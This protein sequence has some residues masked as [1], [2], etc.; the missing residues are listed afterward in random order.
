MAGP[1][2]DER[3]RRRNRIGPL[4]PGP[5]S[6]VTVR[7]LV[8]PSDVPLATDALAKAG[9]WVWVGARADQLRPDEDALLSAERRL[10]WRTPSATTVR[11]QAER[12]AEALTAGSVSYDLV[13]IAVERIRRPSWRYVRGGYGAEIDEHILAG[14]PEQE[15]RDLERVAR[16]HG[17]PVES[18]S[19]AVVPD[20]NLTATRDLLRYRPAAMGLAVIVALCLAAIAWR[21][22]R[23]GPGELVVLAL[24]LGSGLGVYA[25]RRQHGTG[26]LRPLVGQLVAIV[27]LFTAFLVGVIYLSYAYFYAPFGVTPTEVGLTTQSMLARQ[28]FFIALW[29]AVIVAL[30]LMVYGALWSVPQLQSVERRVDVLQAAM[31]PLIV[32]VAV[33]TVLSLT[34]ENGEELGGAARAG[35]PYD[36]FSGGFSWPL[37]REVDVLTDDPRQAGFVAGARLIYLGQADGMAV[38]YDRTSGSTVGLRDVRQLRFRA[39]P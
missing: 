32:A 10:P 13:G 27:P 29:L 36:A 37:P 21:T 12:A 11:A 9:F 38:L 2:R 34:F 15:A 4:R 7:L 39:A 30:T 14:T 35:R 16:R 23:N 5:G 3:A 19:T 17:V 20:T 28:G 31:L 8:A 26:F 24:V 33:L 6:S 22:A 25:L 1:A 18:L